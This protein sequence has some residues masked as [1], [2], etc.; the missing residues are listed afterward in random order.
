MDASVL[1]SER[2]ARRPS[3]GREQ[4]TVLNPAGPPATVPQ[5]GSLTRVVGRDGKM[6]ACLADGR[7]LLVRQRRFGHGRGVKFKIYNSD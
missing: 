5:N 4:S 6:A 7:E 2:Y 1:A 3:P